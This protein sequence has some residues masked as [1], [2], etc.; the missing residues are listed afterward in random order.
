[1]E[2]N[3]TVNNGT[4]CHQLPVSVG[5]STFCGLTKKW[6]S[7]FSHPTLLAMTI[8]PAVFY[9]IVLL[10]FLKTL[11]K[12]L[13][14]VKK[15]KFEETKINAIERC[16][17]LCCNVDEDDFLNVRLY[18]SVVLIVL[19]KYFWDAIDLTL[20][21]YIFYQ[22][23]KGEVLDNLIYRNANV[24][25]SIYGFA[26]LGCVCKVITWKFFS[27]SKFEGS[28]DRRKEISFLMMKNMVI[29][30]S[31]IFEDGPEM[32]LEFFYIEKYV[33]KF[34]WLLLVKDILVGMLAIS[35]CFNAVFYLIKGRKISLWAKTSF[36]RRITI[37]QLFYSVLV[38]SFTLS[39]VLRVVGACYQYFTKKLKRSCFVVENGVILQTPFTSGCMREIDYFIALMAGIPLV[40]FA[41]A[42]LVSF[43]LGCLWAH[44]DRKYPDKTT[45]PIFRNKWFLRFLDIHGVL[46]TFFFHRTGKTIFNCFINIFHQLNKCINCNKTCKKKRSEDGLVPNNVPVKPLVDIRNPRFCYETAV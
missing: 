24:N 39:N 29:V 42:L 12:H 16:F 46:M 7:R 13:M 10:A 1:M 14:N 32:I 40:F 11:H 36:S 19:F 15:L 27:M 18:I 5:N 6:T 30:A 45:G 41:Y 26:L 23:E 17:S 28:F 4:F 31:L 8:V 38:V 34:S 37:P 20:D 33:T 9:W 43:F 21:L 22:L 44:S 2:F 35:T 3:Q 25:N